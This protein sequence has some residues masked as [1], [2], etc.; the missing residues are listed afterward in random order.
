VYVDGAPVAREGGEKRRLFTQ[1]RLNC[2]RSHERGEKLEKKKKEEKEDHGTTPCGLGALY[3]GKRNGRQLGRKSEKGERETDYR[4]K[5]TFCPRA[6]REANRPVKGGYLGG[7]KKLEG[8]ICKIISAGTKDLKK[9]E[10]R[11]QQSGMQTYS[12]K[13]RDLGKEGFSPRLRPGAWQEK[14]GKTT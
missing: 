7:K 1:S 9:G 11:A 3:G 8:K 5:K 12:K 2:A 6:E 4:E 14:E 10:W 13:G